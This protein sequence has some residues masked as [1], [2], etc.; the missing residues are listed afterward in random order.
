MA[1]AFKNA[2]VSVGTT[3]TTLYTCPSGKE[4]VIHALY[5]SNINGTSP[6]T[7]SIEI[8]TDGGSTYFYVGKTLSVPED[9]TLVFDKP[10]NLESGDIL[11]VTAASAGMLEAVCSILEISP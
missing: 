1:N 11:A 8:T 9:S 2:G 10:L 6:A 5:I 4:V 7:A 3:R